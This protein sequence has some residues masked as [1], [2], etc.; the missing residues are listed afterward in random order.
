MR[1]KLS[2]IFVKVDVSLHEVI[3]ARHSLQCLLLVQDTC[4]LTTAKS[5]SIG[6]GSGI[7]WPLP[8]L[9][10]PLAERIVVALAMH[11][12]RLVIVFIVGVVAVGHVLLRARI[13]LADLLTWSR[14]RDG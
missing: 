1:V 8:L 6:A 2:G 12:G 13:F 4:S 11:I 9:L 5:Q 3:L 10:H 14:L 7:V